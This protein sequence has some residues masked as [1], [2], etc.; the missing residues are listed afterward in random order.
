MIIM[1]NEI[2][3]QQN[4]SIYW[5]AK[6]INCDYQSLKRFANNDSTKVSLYLIENIC[7]AL[8]CTPDSLFRIEE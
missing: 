5:L 8:S 3:A 6:T 7:K 2:L 1:L 4:K